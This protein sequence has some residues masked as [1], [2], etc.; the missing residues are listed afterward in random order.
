MSRKKVVVI[1]A[2]AGGLMAAGRAAEC[3]AEVLLLE[4]MNRPGRKLLLTGNSRCNLTNSRDLD[5]FIPMYGPSGRFLYPAFRCFFR[6]DLVSLLKKH[7]VAAQQENDGR[8]FP[9]SGKAADVLHALEQ[10][11]RSGGAAIRTNTAVSSIDVKDGSVTGVCTAGCA[12][13]AD[14][15]VLAAGGASYPQTGS[16]GDGV[17]VAAALG[18]RI[19]KLRPALVPL[20][21]NDN[22][23]VRQ[24]QGLTLR[25]V[26]VTSYAC[27]TRDI[28]AVKQVSVDAG[29]GIPGRKARLPLIESRRGDIVFTHFGISG[30]PV[31]LMSLPV[32]CALEEGPVSLAIDLLPDKDPEQA[33]HELQALITSHGKQQVHNILSTLVPARLAGLLLAQI[34]MEAG[35]KCNQVATFQRKELTRILKSFALEI[36]GVRP[37]A[38]AMVTAGGISLDEIDARTLQ[39]RL[40]K[41]LY[42]CGEVMDIDADTG[43]FNLQAAFSTGWLAGESAAASF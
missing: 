37:L 3:G 23:S 26:R 25:N 34:G 41:G 29:R 4:K 30:P 5:D 35:E 38:E 15:V 39:S 22:P 24:L 33:G 27:T 32:A 43:G 40:V 10:F 12:F 20:V 16:N 18:H 21:I 14:A 1:G 31:L 42:F 7:G 2:G 28:P 11:A 6:E 9:A 17:K 8:V 36:S 19:S 13:S